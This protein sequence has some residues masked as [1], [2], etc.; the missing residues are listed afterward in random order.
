MLIQIIKGAGIKIKTIEMLYSEIPIVSTVVGVE[1]ILVDNGKE[2]LLA[3]NEKEFIEHIIL[4]K[5]KK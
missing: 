2:Y 1:G 5:V 4:L 3:K